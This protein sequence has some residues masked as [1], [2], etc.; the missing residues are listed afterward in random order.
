MNIIDFKRQFEHPVF[1]SDISS[2]VWANIWLQ[3][4]QKHQNLI[5][6]QW[7]GRIV[8]STYVSWAHATTDDI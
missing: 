6:I 5:N 2:H 3:T 1:L 7:L 8:N 4:G